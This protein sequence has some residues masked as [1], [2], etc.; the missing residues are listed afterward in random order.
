[1]SRARSSGTEKAPPG[2]AGERPLPVRA[3]L[4]APAH[5]IRRLRLFS[6]NKVAS[7]LTQ[8]EM[9]G[10]ASQRASTGKRGDH[11]SLGSG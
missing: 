3:A 7:P 1:M 8:G 5:I 2:G 11:G 4:P 9:S 6:R 10:S